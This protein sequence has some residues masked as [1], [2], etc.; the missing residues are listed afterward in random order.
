VWGEGA[1]SSLAPRSDVEA[2]GLSK[3]PL[4]EGG[5]GLGNPG[6]LVRLSP[7]FL[8]QPQKRK[9]GPATLLHSL[10]RGRRISQPPV[11]SAQASDLLYTRAVISSR[12]PRSGY[13]EF[14]TL[15]KD[16]DP[17]IPILKQAKA[18][19]AKLH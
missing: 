12:A 11:R 6:F 3:P 4:F 9:G 10:H 17:E 14:L 18:E 16:A 5:W 15:W 13:Q 2:A 19:Y 1:V 7:G 8:S